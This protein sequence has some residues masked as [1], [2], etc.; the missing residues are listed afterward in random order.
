MGFRWANYDVFPWIRFYPEPAGGIIEGECGNYVMNDFLMRLCELASSLAVVFMSREG[1]RR[2]YMLR[3]PCAEEVLPSVLRFPNIEAP[4]MLTMIY[5]LTD[6]IARAIA[7]HCTNWII[8]ACM[9]LFFPV[10]TLLLGSF[11]RALYEHR[12]GRAQGRAPGL[13]EESYRDSAWAFFFVEG[14]RKLLLA[15]IL[16]LTFSE[17]RAVLMCV[18]CGAH[19]GLISFFLPIQSKLCMFQIGLIACCDTVAV[20]FAASPV[21]QWTDADMAA[22][23]A[24]IFAL[25]SLLAS[26]AGLVSATIISLT[27]FA[28]K[29]L[30]A[31][32]ETLDLTILNDVKVEDDG[33]ANSAFTSPELQRASTLR[34]SVLGGQSPFPTLGMSSALVYADEGGVQNPGAIAMAQRHFAGLCASVLSRWRGRVS[35][36][37]WV[38]LVEQMYVMVSIGMPRERCMEPKVISLHKTGMAVPLRAWR[39]VAVRRSRNRGV[40]EELL[41][42][43]QRV[44]AREWRVAAIRGEN[45]RNTSLESFERSVESRASPLG[46]F[47]AWVRWTRRAQAFQDLWKRAAGDKLVLMARQALRSWRGVVEKRWT[48]SDGESMMKVSKEGRLK[49]QAM[50][51]WHLVAAADAERK[52]GLLER[53]IKGWRWRAARRRELAVMEIELSASA[54]MAPADRAMRKW[55]GLCSKERAVRGRLEELD[56]DGRSRGFEGWRESVGVAIKIRDARFKAMTSRRDLLLLAEYF[57]TWPVPGQHVI[58]PVPGQHV[59]LQARSP[60]GHGSSETS[61]WAP[62]VHEKALARDSASLQGSGVAMRPFMLPLPDEPPMSIANYAHV[63]SP[64]NFFQSP[65]QR[66]PPSGTDGMFLGGSGA[67]RGRTGI[68][69]HDM[70]VLT[71]LEDDKVDE[72]GSNDDIDKDLAGHGVGIYGGMLSPFFN[73]ASPLL[74]IVTSASPDGSRQVSP[75]SQVQHANGYRLSSS[76]FKDEASPPSSGELGGAIS[77]LLPNYDN[78]G[79]EQHGRGVAS[80]RWPALN[81]TLDHS[82]SRRSGSSNTSDFGAADGG[83]LFKEVF[84]PGGPG[85]THRGRRWA[86]A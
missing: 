51:A 46:A 41:A 78:D 14:V 38:N 9:V 27:P 73:S 35:R 7:T 42:R 19:L 83:L 45:V 63:P 20:V 50:R 86:F 31:Y 26:C 71:A 84:P 29:L 1:A 79:T 28:C 53:V 32:D 11:A 85:A 30:D 52:G 49:V 5:P 6:V 23:Y 34:K 72:T 62:L 44:V 66:S 13:L 77:V 15:M 76:L 16:G 58:W 18:S 21:Y 43:K 47:G 55:A 36:G 8:T 59:T 22:T 54:R 64:P 61:S 74:K 57:A 56:K 10:V 75:P 25:I 2:V 3:Y 4:C 60:R 12:T 68:S 65:L 40:V 24:I 17:A 81:G 37:K 70:D 67:L 33:A 80:L 82:S 48:L 39:R 69:L